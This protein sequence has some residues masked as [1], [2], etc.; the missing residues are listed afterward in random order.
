MSAACV[1]DA[2]FK[3]ASFTGVSSRLDPA[4]AAAWSRHLVH[5]RGAYFAVLDEI[6]I[7]AGRTE[8]EA[9]HMVCR[10]RSYH[11]GRMVD[12]RR[13]TAEDGQTGVKLH[14]VSAAP[15]PASVT[16]E[17]RDGAA[18][19]T[20]LRQSR[21]GRYAPGGRVTFQNIFYA[22]APD[23][24]R[25][26]DARPRGDRAMLVKGRSEGFNGVDLVACGPLKLPGL[27]EC[28]GALC[29]IGSDQ[30][31]FAG[32]RTLA[33]AN[34]FRLEASAPVTVVLRAQDS[35]IE[36]SETVRVHASGVKL[37]ARFEAGRHDLGLGNAA[38]LLAKVA[39]HLAALWQRADT[40]S[41][42]RE[43]AKPLDAAKGSPHELSSL[44]R[45]EPGPK[46]HYTVRADG[47][48]KPLDGHPYS[49][50][51][52][53]FNWVDRAIPWLS[54][55]VP[56]WQSG[57]GTVLLDLRERVAVRA[58]RFVWP[59]HY[60]SHRFKTKVLSPDEVAVQVQ[61]SDDHFASDC[62]TASPGAAKSTWHYV[63][64][65][66]YMSTARFPR[67]TVPVA[68]TGRYMRVKVGPKPGGRRDRVLFSEIEV[69]AEQSEDR[70]CLRMRAASHAK[71]GDVDLA[72]W[73][74]SKLV[75]LDSR[76]GRVVARDLAA[77]IVDLKF[78][79]IDGD[80]REEV[81]VY[82]LDDV[83]TAIDPD[84]GERF[85]R[86]LARFGGG[87]G[88]WL[89]SS[90]PACF[91]AWR[92]DKKGRLETIFFPHY[93]MMRV[94]AEPELSHTWPK[95]GHTW[96]GKA[97]FTIPD[98]TGDGR[99]DL[100]VVG[101]YSGRAVRV[102][103]SDSALEQGECR[104]VHSHPF[105][106]YSSG[107]MELPQYFDGH[108][109]GKGPSW[110]A[111]VTLTPGGMDCFAAPDFR[112]TWKHFNHPP[113]R[114]S[115][116]WRG[117]DRAPALVV[118]RGDGFVCRYAIHDGT[119]TDRA[120]VGRDVR[121]VAAHAG[122]LAAGGPDGLVLLDNALHE[123]SRLRRPVDALAAI[124]D[125]LMVAFSDGEVAACR[126]VHASAAH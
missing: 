13:F 8:A 75:L 33:A 6:G 25:A 21:F 49:W 20:I 98:L 40:L 102:L 32:C 31:V 22:E 77:P 67:L 78:A 4:S 68:M 120:F 125:R 104:V 62:R 113:N 2:S 47:D 28:D 18:R 92:A 34:V 9:H 121:A 73:S 3:T 114:C 58:L 81:L 36:T 1:L 80:R 88:S 107:N 86:E 17:P 84:G 116:L 61:M 95:A 14:I 85:R 118:G 72:V 108:V 109:V 70:T 27:V 126:P 64:N 82:T 103:A 76:S 12:G 26:F 50:A 37:A 122:W 123:R 79:D 55:H 29:A 56:G 41:T 15:V 100:V 91:A 43:A 115:T 105:T 94:S 23:R 45:I 59:G 63:E 89:S 38:G 54:P 96:G 7:P 30:A 99:D 10:W 39:P 69:L 19:P 87:R 119:L 71:P 101:T 106:G 46:V 60:Q 112:A 90:R 42:S 48:P 52:N 117:V 24:A 35:Y 124:G 51:R 11:P 83:F 66:H 97:A 53:P 93:N 5:R 111:V 57:E 65:A 110:Q 44:A 16:L 74:P